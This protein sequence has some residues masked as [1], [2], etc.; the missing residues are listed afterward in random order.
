MGLL[1]Y[2]AAGTSLMGLVGKRAHREITLESEVPNFGL[3]PSVAERL[4]D[5]LD[6]RRKEDPFASGRQ[7]VQE[8]DIRERLKQHQGPRIRSTFKPDVQP[9]PPVEPPEPKPLR[10]F[11]FETPQP[12]AEQR[13]EQRWE[14]SPPS[15]EVEEPSAAEAGPLT[16]AKFV[17]KL[18]MAR[19]VVTRSGGGARLIRNIKRQ[20]KRPSFYRSAEGAR[21]R[22]SPGWMAV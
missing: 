18:K 15:P 19:R 2:L 21:Q 13:L 12:V 14:P 9:A 8:R 3:K 6:M 1:N 7:D 22:R 10:S 11:R 4:R 5:A 17:R 20:P 16:K